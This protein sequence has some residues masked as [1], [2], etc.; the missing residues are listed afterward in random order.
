M[1]LVRKY[2]MLL[3]LLI[4]SLGL[5]ILYRFQTKGATNNKTKVENPKKIIFETLTQSGMDA[6]TAR[7]WVA[8]SAHETGGWTSRIYRENHNLFGMR[9]P[10]VNTTA[11]GARYGH[12]VFR[13]DSDSAKDLVKY[14]DRLKWKQINFSDSDSLVDEM[15]RKKYFEAPL[16]LYKS[17]VKKWLAKL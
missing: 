1:G 8:V 9:L 6:V 11:I 14:F 13:S 16:D 4:G 5:W 12:A 15:K 17:A 3:T 2:G 10:S 7:F